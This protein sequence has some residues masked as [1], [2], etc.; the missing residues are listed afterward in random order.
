MA[1]ADD[2]SWDGITLAVSL[3]AVFYLVDLR[4][5]FRGGE[6]G[7]AF[8]Y[9]VVAAAVFCVGFVLRLALDLISVTPESYGLSVRDPAIIIA[10]VLVALGLRGLSKFWSHK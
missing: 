2:L 4:R 10:L 1:L 8:N 7:S 5:T 6:M 9:F 3:V